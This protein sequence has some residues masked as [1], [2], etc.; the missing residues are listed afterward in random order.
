MKR[1]AAAAY[2]DHALRMTSGASAAP[3]V[4]VVGYTPKFGCG[5][6]AGGDA[7][8]ESWLCMC[9]RSSS[10]VG[11]CLPQYIQNSACAVLGAGGGATAGGEGSA[12][13]P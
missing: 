2:D 13:A 1:D 3:L 5:N 9:S 10:S 12:P 11:Q 6:G 4:G 8:G 7:A